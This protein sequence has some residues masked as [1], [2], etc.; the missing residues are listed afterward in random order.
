M[1]YPIPLKLCIIMVASPSYLHFATYTHCTQSVKYGLFSH[2][3]YS[4]ARYVKVIRIVVSITLYII[5]IFTRRR[6]IV[7]MWFLRWERLRPSVRGVGRGNFI[8]E[9]F[10]RIINTN[11]IKLFLSKNP[12]LLWLL[13]YISG[14]MAEHLYN[15][16]FRRYG[17]L[18]LFLIHMFGLSFTFSANPSRYQKL[19]TRASVNTRIISCFQNLQTY[20]T[21]MQMI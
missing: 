4:Y 5:K 21:L 11:Y 15:F 13:I 7:D 18:F 17:D 16:S 8:L 10:E 3:R 9:I 1:T 14:L 6:V 2:W 19:N 12:I 20:F